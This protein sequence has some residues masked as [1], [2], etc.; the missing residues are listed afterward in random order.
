MVKT[1]VLH[2]ELENF[3]HSY[4]GPLCVVGVQSVRTNSDHVGWMFT[5]ALHSCQEFGSS[6]LKTIV[7][8]RINAIRQTK[9]NA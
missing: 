6:S 9:N 3:V 8:K 4:W 1:N 7:E 2:F 5:A